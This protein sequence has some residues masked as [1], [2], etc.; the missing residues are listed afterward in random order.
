MTALAGMLIRPMPFTPKRGAPE[1]Y[2]RVREQ[3]RL[4]LEARSRERVFE[5]LDVVDSQGLCRLPEPSPGDMFLDLEGDPFAGPVSGPP[6][7]RGRE[8]LFGRGERRS[9]RRDGVSGVLGRERLRTRRRRSRRS[10]I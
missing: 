7:L 9:V 2:Q 4:Q 8:Y 10:S 3:A 5:L 6:M 1:S